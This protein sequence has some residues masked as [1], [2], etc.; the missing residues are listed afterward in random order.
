MIL[1]CLIESNESSLC[2]LLH[3]FMWM[4]LPLKYLCLWWEYV[5]ED[6]NDLG[7][8]SIALPVVPVRHSWGTA[9]S[10]KLVEFGIV[11]TFGNPVTCTIGT[12]LGQVETD[13]LSSTVQI[14]DAV[15]KGTLSVGVVIL[16]DGFPSVGPVGPGDEEGATEVGSSEGDVTPYCSIAFTAGFTDAA[17]AVWGDTLRCYCALAINGSHP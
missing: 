1:I 12:E 13:G 17:Q 8:A 11:F 10:T 9:I 2:A 15:L 14:V 7:A 16:E 5:L 6:T 3:K 4:F